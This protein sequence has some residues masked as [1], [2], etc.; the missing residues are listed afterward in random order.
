MHKRQHANWLARRTFLVGSSVAIAGLP[1][2]GWAQ[3]ESP[4]VEAPKPTFSLKE[5]QWRP[6]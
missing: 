6:V 1:E 4:K 3:G 5:I 2:L